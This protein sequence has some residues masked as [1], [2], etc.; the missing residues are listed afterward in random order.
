VTKQQ[1]EQLGKE[2]GY[3]FMETSALNGTNVNEVFHTMLTEV[4]KNMNILK[5]SRED[6]TNSPPPSGTVD[7]Q[8]ADAYAKDGSAAQGVLD[9][10]VNA[11]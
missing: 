11:C 2:I 3:K 10:V 6:S 9:A 1:A 4:L 5:R 8:S 7:I